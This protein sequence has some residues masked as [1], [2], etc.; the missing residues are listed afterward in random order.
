M[1]IPSQIWGEDVHIDRAKV[2]ANLE[3]IQKSIAH[4][5]IK[6]IAVT[7]YFGLDAIKAGFEVG[8]R[9][10]GESRAVDAVNKIEVIENVL[11]E[12]CRKLNEVF[13]HYINSKKPFMVMK[14]A[15]TIDGKIA[16]VGGKSKW[17]TSEK[18]REH[19]HYLRKKYSAIMVGINTVI[20]DNP[21]LNCRIK[22]NHKNPTRIILDSDLKIN[23][24]SNICKTSKDIK[25]YIATIKSNKNSDKR[26][27]LK[28]LGI[29]IIETSSKNKKV[30]LKELIKILGEEKNIDSVLIEGGSILH[31]SLLKEKLI[32]K[33]LIYIAPKIFGGLNAKTPISGEGIKEIEKAI[34]LID[35]NIEK[36]GEDLFMEYYLKY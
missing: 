35:G 29:E 8:I 18:A 10:F 26:K 28:D 34:K 19:A 3:E 17:I 33:A 16:T 6:I 11:E 30:N 12:E 14:Y 31:A 22:D 23:L 13:F 32:D 5:K 4:S 9:D 20:E 2:K 21:T 24:K 15:M 27:K 25:T 36:I 1:L 7:K